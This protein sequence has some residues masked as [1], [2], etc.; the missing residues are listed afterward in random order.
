MP[1]LRATA[2]KTD[3]L[4]VANLLVLRG[5]SGICLVGVGAGIAL[6]TRPSILSGNATEEEDNDVNV[7]R[8]QAHDEATRHRPRQRC[9]N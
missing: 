4:E 3:Q 9:G 5:F 6:I 2:A 7:G 1:K 8:N